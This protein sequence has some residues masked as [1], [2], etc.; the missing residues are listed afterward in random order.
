[1]CSSDLKAVGTQ[2]KVY[3]YVPFAGAINADTVRRK[4]PGVE[5]PVDKILALENL[6]HY[7]NLLTIWQFVGLDGGT[8]AVPAQ[9]DVVL[10]ANYPVLHDQKLTDTPGKDIPGVNKAVFRALKPGAVYVVSG[11]RDMAGT[12][13]AR[14]DTLGRAEEA[15]V[16]SEL[17][18]AGFVLDG[19]SSAL[20]NA[21]DDHTKPATADSDRFLLR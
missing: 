8:F 10:T 21:S 17:L 5:Q 6:V 1:M 11:A 3:A 9:A 2:G 15:V 14:A 18:A 13:F 16:K 19:E 7:P 20:A 12:S 4:Y